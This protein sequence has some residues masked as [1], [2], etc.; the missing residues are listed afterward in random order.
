MRQ[1]ARERGRPE[2]APQDYTDAAVVDERI[3]QAIEKIVTLDGLEI[4]VCGS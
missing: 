2:P 4:G 3:R 1:K